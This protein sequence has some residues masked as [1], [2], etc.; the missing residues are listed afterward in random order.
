MLLDR[1]YELEPASRTAWL[2]GLRDAWRLQGWAMSM[3]DRRRMLQLAAAW[4][5][6]PLTCEF[7]Q[8]LRAFGAL[9]GED[10]LRLIDAWRHLGKGEVACDLVRSLQLARPGEELYADVHRELQSWLQWRARMPV[11]RGEDWSDGELNLEPLA[12]HHVYD[13][14]WQYYDPMIAVLCCLPCFSNEG[15]WHDWLD[16]VYARGDQRIFAVLQR[17]WGFIG[18]VSLFLHDDVGFF[19]YWLGPD[20]QGQGYGPRAVLLML[21]MAQQ[22]YGMRSCY[23]KVFNCNEPSRRALE[24]LGFAHLGI[25]GIAPDDDQSFFRWG[26]ARPRPGIVSELHWLLAHIESDTRAAAMVIPQTDWR[27]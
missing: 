15:E 12:H 18:C 16:A 27:P 19:Y 22:D 11:V 4:N 25:S 1:S 6:W 21:A 5:A 3:V 17:E 26:D 2:V 24:K 20:F 23:A 10:T 7:G 9:D 14:A 13:F 8:T